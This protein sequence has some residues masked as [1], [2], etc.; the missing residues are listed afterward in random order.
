MSTQVL[1]EVV[2]R[3]W[4]PVI[5]IEESLHKGIKDEVRKLAAKSESES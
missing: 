2:K 5:K 4:V 3:G 1:K